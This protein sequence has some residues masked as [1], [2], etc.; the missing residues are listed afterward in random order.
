MS[1][2][3]RNVVRPYEN[4]QKENKFCVSDD[5]SRASLNVLCVCLSPYLEFSLFLELQLLVNSI[6]MCYNA[7]DCVFV[8]SNYLLC[9][10]TVITQSV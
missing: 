9:K 5:S 6:E 1:F 4:R 10:R 7:A 2:M 3:E 8:L